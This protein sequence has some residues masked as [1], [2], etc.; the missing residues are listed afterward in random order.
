MFSICFYVPEDAA[1]AVKEAM[2]A[3]GAGR[4]GAYD[5]CCWQSLG[6]GQFRPLSGAKPA[7]GRLHADSFVPELRIEMICDDEHLEA[8]IAALLAAHPYEMPAYHYWPVNLP[9]NSPPC[10]SPAMPPLSNDR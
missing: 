4:L 9:L 3:A 7:I 1:D 10:S 8:A 2:F 5:R 6:Q